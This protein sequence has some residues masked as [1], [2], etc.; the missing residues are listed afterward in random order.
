LKPATLEDENTSRQDAKAQSG[1]ATKLGRLFLFP[2]ASWRLCERHFETASNQGDYC[3][4]SS[5]V[6]SVCVR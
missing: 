5:N 1:V 4:V 3:R 2:F 6:V